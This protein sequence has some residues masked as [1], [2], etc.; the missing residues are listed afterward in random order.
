MKVRIAV[1]PPEA[2]TFAAPDF[3][4]DSGVGVRYC[5]LCIENVR[6]TLPDGR[7]VVL[8]RRGLKITLQLGDERADALLRRLEHGPDVRRIFRAAL[9]EAAGALGAR[10]FEEQGA[11]WLELDA[12]TRSANP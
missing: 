8:K 10:A 7:R 12:E 1:L 5:D 3:E 6:A 4:D 9:D 11:L 2:E